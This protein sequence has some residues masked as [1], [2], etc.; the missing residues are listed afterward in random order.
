MT[1]SF[2]LAS[3]PP[4]PAG[5]TLTVCSPGGTCTPISP[6]PLQAD[7]G[8]RSRST[9]VSRAPLRGVAARSD[10]M[11]A[12]SMAMTTVRSGPV[13]A[14]Y[15]GPPRRTSETE[16]A[17]PGFSHDVASAGV[18]LRPPYRTPLPTRKMTK[19][20]TSSP[21]D[22]TRRLPNLSLGS[23][24]DSSGSSGSPSSECGPRRIAS[25]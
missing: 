7:I 16:I 10:V 21:T 14:K 17:R 6:L 18:W 20:P 12:A 4:P 1:V 13:I 24:R 8:T 2:L 25:S 23:G 11:D 22:P 5:K 9:W 19:I 15:S 3:A